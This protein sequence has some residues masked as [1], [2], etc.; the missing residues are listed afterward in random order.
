M[1]DT[2]PRLIESLREELKQYGHLLLL[3]DE[4]QE[5]I[6][7]RQN[8]SLLDATAAIQEQGAAIQAARRE[9]E[10]IQRELA[11]ALPAAT[12]PSLRALTLLPPDY[13]PLL[14]ALVQENHQLLRR[15]RQRAHQNHLLLRRSL[16]L[17]DQ[18]LQTL[19]PTGPAVYDGAGGLPGRR[20]PRCR[21]L[22]SSRLT[23][24]MLG[25]HGTLN[26]GVRSL[27]TQSQGL[28]VAGQNL[29]NVHNPAYT[30]QRL[31]LQT[32]TP[33]QGVFGSQGTGVGAQAIQ[34]VLSSLLDRQIQSETSVSGFWEAHRTA[35]ELAQA[36]LAES[37]N[38]RTQT[39]AG[40]AAAGE[41]GAASTLASELSAFF[42]EWQNLAATPASLAQRSTLLAR[43][44]S[45]AAQF[46]Q[47]DARLGQ[48]NAQLNASVDTDVAQANELLTAIA[49]LNEQIRRA[50]LGR[51]GSAND[52][53]D[54]RR[55]KLESLA[56]LA[57]VDTAET[58]DGQFTLAVGGVQLVAGRN[59][60]DTLATSND[61]NGQH[62]VRTTTTA[63]PSPSP[64]AAS[65]APSTPAT[66]PSPPSAPTSIPSPPPSS[67]RSTPSIAP[68]ST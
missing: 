21:P 32:T 31:L 20:L 17:L 6:I 27:Q 11:A 61:A 44:Q 68:A 57:N 63:T 46:Q 33:L 52:L 58:P 45:L 55:Q 38:S 43:A 22:R 35:L 8:E 66:V 24:P 9:R 56:T 16:E 42:N 1:N 18:F 59:V 34:Q 37:F 48:L 29:A 19:A 15:V 65:P 13:R 36:H 40:T 41:A 39:A 3:L 60:L 64:P 53:R 28:A 10:A 30:R 50:E 12:D 62:L 23:S 49:R 54:L 67:A 51:P 4:Q 47:T 26:L 25:L 2:L 14:E 7:R 5:G